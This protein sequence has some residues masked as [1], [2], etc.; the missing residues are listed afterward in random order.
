MYTRTELHADL[1]HII[2]SI[3]REEPKGTSTYRH[4]VENGS[5]F[6]LA[7]LHPSSGIPNFPISLYLKKPKRSAA[8][9]SSHSFTKSSRAWRTRAEKQKNKSKGLTPLLL[10]TSPVC[11]FTQNY[12][13]PSNWW[14]PET[15]IRS[16]HHDS[17]RSLPCFD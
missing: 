6:D 4:L 7:C 9:E 2:L 5:L 15:G 13:I 14:Q 3:L 12:H 1:T 16:K 10:C 17:P 11:L 8:D